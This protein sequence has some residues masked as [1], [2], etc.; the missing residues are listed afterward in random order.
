MLPTLPTETRRFLFQRGM[1]PG[2]DETVRVNVRDTR[3]L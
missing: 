2:E 3:E 1:S